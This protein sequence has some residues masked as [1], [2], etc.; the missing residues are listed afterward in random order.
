MRRGGLDVCPVGPGASAPVHP[1]IGGF[2][3]KIMGIKL[4]TLLSGSEKK[5]QWLC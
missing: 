5:V 3:G 2:C 1:F 4:K